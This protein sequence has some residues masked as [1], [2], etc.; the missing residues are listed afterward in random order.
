MPVTGENY[1]QPMKILWK[2]SSREFD[3][4]TRNAKSK[5]DFNAQVK[6]LR[7]KY[8]T[9]SRGDRYEKAEAE[10]NKKRKMSKEV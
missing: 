10:K 7:A 6:V 3:S 4:V 1:D 9:G 2:A 8:K 5:T